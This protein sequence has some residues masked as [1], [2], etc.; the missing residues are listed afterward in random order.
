MYCKLDNEHGPFDII[1]DIHGCAHELTLLLE[2]LGYRPHVSGATSSGA[3]SDAPIY[4]HPESRK[5]IFVGD[6]VDRGPQILDTLRLVHNMVHAGSALCVIGN[7]DDKLHRL[8]KGNN[9]QVKHGLEHTKAELDALPEPVHATLTIELR[10]FLETL[11][12]HYILDDGKLVIAHAGI[13]EELHGTVSEKTRSFALYGETTGQKDEYGLP[14][15]GNWPEKY[16]GKAW[17]IYGH[18]PVPEP[19]WLNHTVNVDTGCV[20]GGKLTALRYP[21]METVSVVAKQVY[22]ESARPFPIAAES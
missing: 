8:L 17:V 2:Q 13:K 10:Q 3:L 4:R 21:E 22:Y 14:I 18:T 16:Q 15:R 6:L 20:F 12:N 9:V 5:A 7:H 1:G 19:V 11:P